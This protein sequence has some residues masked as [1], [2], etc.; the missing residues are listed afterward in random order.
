MKTTVQNDSVCPPLHAKL[1]D[2]VSLD[3]MLGLHVSERCIAVYAVPF[4]LLF[5]VDL[6]THVQQL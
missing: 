1:R 6:L 4:M 2:I 3:Y 5:Q